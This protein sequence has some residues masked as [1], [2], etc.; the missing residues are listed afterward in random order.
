MRRFL[1]L[2]DRELK[3][4]FYSGIA[5]VVLFFLLLLTGWNFFSVISLLNHGPADVT[6]VEGFFGLVTFWFPFVL[7]FPIITMRSFSQEY[8]MGTFEPLTTAPVR[9]WQVVLS[10]YTATVLFYLV[11][12][13]P[14]LLYFYLFDWVTLGQAAHAAGAYWGSYLLLLVM[15]MFYLSIGCLASA[16][17]KDQ[18]NAAV[19]AF[20]AIT[21]TFFLGLLTYIVPGLPGWVREAVTYMSAVEQMKEF[22]RGIIDT[23]PIAFYLSMTTLMLVLTYHVF[24]YRKWKA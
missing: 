23:R 2:L 9:D 4:F 18:I 13:L 20:C 15:G 14:S 5:Y 21:L 7:T 8:Q 24:Q 17:T 10:K 1:T 12:W 22:S 11:I 19:I 3:S 16:L 6:V